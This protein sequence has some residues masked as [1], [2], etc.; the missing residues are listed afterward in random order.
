MEKTMKRKLLIATAA[1]A[2]I[3]GSGL[4][5]AQS[6][7]A[8]QG[9]A[10]KASSDVKQAPRTGDTS[11]VGGT[12]SADSQA[13]SGKKGSLSQNNAPIGSA[14]QQADTKKQAEGT[15]DSSKVGGT[16]SGNASAMQKQSGPKTI[17]GA[18]VGSAAQKAD[19]AQQG[20]RTGD[21]ETKG[22]MKKKS[23]M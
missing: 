21:A 18:P 14:P 8:R 22:G 16:T 15:G 17:N 12:P 7:S 10:E 9:T 19:Q 11:K 20:A 5:F 6:P 3:A 1:A 4:S 13:K 2:L 23:P